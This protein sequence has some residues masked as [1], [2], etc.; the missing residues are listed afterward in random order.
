MVENDQKKKTKK[1]IRPK[2]GLLKKKKKKKKKKTVTFDMVQSS[3]LVR[4]W[5]SAKMN[6]RKINFTTTTPFFNLFLPK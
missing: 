6:V 3:N 4:A 2:G 1:K 5:H